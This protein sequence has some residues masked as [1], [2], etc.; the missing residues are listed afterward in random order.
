[1]FDG[2]RRSL[3]SSRSYSNG[4][5]KVF[6]ARSLFGV[7]FAK[8]FSFSLSL[9]AENF[10]AGSQYMCTCAEGEKLTLEL[11]LMTQII[12]PAPFNPPNKYFR[13][14]PR[15]RVH[16]RRASSPRRFTL[17]VRFVFSSKRSTYIC[18]V[19][20]FDEYNNDERKRKTLLPCPGN[21]AKKCKLN[22]VSYYAD[23]AFT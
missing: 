16:P 3:P 4:R 10:Y 15:A 21:A 14:S 11:L 1:M 18:F 22:Y 13:Y 17:F 19:S 8:L 6:L 2:R 12:G 5:A 7:C 20:S 23:P 9:S